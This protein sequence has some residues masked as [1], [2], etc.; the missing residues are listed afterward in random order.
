[1]WKCV[2]QAWESAVVRAASVGKRG[3]RGKCGEGQSSGKCRSMRKVRVSGVSAVAG[4]SVC[5]CARLINADMLLLCWGSTG[6]FVTA[7]HGT[8]P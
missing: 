3:E 8:L 5:H 2:Q 4:V 1:M 6:R 7:G